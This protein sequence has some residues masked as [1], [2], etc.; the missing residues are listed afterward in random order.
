MVQATLEHLFEQEK[1]REFFSSW[2]EAKVLADAETSEW[3]K[4]GANL[5]R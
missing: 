1:I 5:T 3:H 4:G 2:R